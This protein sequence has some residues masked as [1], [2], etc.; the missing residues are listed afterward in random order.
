MHR[1][2]LL[3]ASALLGLT[4]LMSGPGCD[5]LVTES[6]TTVVFN[7]PEAEFSA[8]KREGCAPCTVTF[9]DESN[10]P[11]EEWSWIIRYAEMADLIVDSSRDTNPRFVFIE[12]GFYSVSLLVRDSLGRSDSESKTRYILVSNPIAS[13]RTGGE[14]LVCV[15]T[16]IE[17]INESH[18]GITDYKWMFYTADS[19]YIDSSY[20]SNPDYVFTQPGVYSVSLTVSGACG[21]S[22]LVVQDML[23][24]RSC[25]LVDFTVNGGLTQDTVCQLEP[26]TVDFTIGQGAVDSIWWYFSTQDSTRG[27]IS[28]VVF[29][30]YGTASTGVRNVWNKVYTEGLLLSDTLKSIVV[31]SP[32]ASA[33]INSTIQ[34]D[35]NVTSVLFAAS[36]QTNA[37]SYQWDFG[38]GQ[39]ATGANASH[40]YDAAGDYTIQLVVDNDC[41]RPDTAA[42][43]ITVTDST[44]FE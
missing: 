40:T 11:V 1:K 7:Y 41:N 34:A 37:T 13:F 24:V 12:P 44:Y 17:F 30:G 23:D 21:E 19:S 14:Q 43:T 25:A 15:G 31:I 22:T 8:N 16:R 29:N 9:S 10:G 3:A 28:P 38:D 26:I 36:Q 18:G 39:T 42:E 33:V 4:F 35:S 20:R 5:E 6:N 27:E 32:V 2:L